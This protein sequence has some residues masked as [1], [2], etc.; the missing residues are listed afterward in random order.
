MI[1]N[2]GYFYLSKYNIRN[3]GNEITSLY[4]QCHLM[5]ITGLIDDI[6][7]NEL[8]YRYNTELAESLNI[9]SGDHEKIKLKDLQKALENV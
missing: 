8:I 4:V 9:R 3:S 6:L 7:T 1:R 5:N 2:S